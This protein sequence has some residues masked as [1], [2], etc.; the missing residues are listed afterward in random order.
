MRLG[1]L[2][3]PINPADPDALAEQA[4]Q[5]EGEGYSSLWS[6]Q[7][8]GRGHFVPDPFITLSIAAAVTKNVELGTG[9]L[10]LP[11]YHPAD[12]AIKA[13]SLMQASGSRLL[14]G[15]GAGSTESD[16]RVHGS[17]FDTR[18][19]RYRESVKD[20]R[21]IFATGEVGDYNLSP[22]EQVQGGPPLFY[23]TWGA[24]VAKAADEYDGWIASGMHRTPDDLD[25]VIPSYRQA[26]GQRAIVSTILASA[27]RGIDG[28]AELLQRFEAAGFDDAVVM[29]LPGGPSPADF[30]K[31]VKS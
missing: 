15:L 29:F 21:H 6:A 13:F 14:L 22:Y 28:L 30:R 9:I 19:R 17:T 1:A 20:L 11:L 16:H 4:R 31:L 25:E 2:L 18:F 26:G 23:G 7:A 24:G 12:V 10:Q 5:L 3:G 8:I 27:D